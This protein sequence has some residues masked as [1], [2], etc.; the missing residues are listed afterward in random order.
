MKT[1]GLF[2]FAA[3]IAL[4][5]AFACGG[6][7]AETATVPP[8]APTATTAPSKAPTATLAPVAPTATSVP[9]TPTATV[10]P[11]TS[12]PV[13]TASDAV[14][15]L[16]NPKNTRGNVVF[17]LPDFDFTGGLNSV[18]AAYMEGVT[19]NL[20]WPTKEGLAT[21][22]IAKSWVVAN[23]LKSITITIRNGVSFHQ[24]FGE[25]TAEDV[26]WSFNDA[27]PG[28]TPDSITD[29][30]GQWTFFLGKNK[31]LAVD[32]YTVKFDLQMFDPRWDTSFFSQDGLSAS[33]TSKKAFD[34]KGRDWMLEHLV[35]TGP[36]EATELKTKDHALLTRV[37]NHWRAKP[38]VKTF[39]IQA[40]PDAGV[41]QATIETGEADVAM[42]DLN[43]ASD[44]LSRGFKQ[45]GNSKARQFMIVFNGNYWEDKNP[46]NGETIVFKE[47]YQQDVP[48]IGNPF[49]P[50][51]ANNP[52]GID[53]MEQARLV[54]QA[55]ARALDRNLLNEILLGGLGWPI[56][57]PYPGTRVPSWDHTKWVFPFD[58]K[59]AERLLEKAGYPKGA[60]G[61]RLQVPIVAS[62]DY[63]PE[64]SELSDAMAGMWQKV[65][66]KTAVVKAQYSAY[67]RPKLVGR[68]AEEPFLTACGGADSGRPPDWPLYEQFSALTRPGFNCGAELPF[69]TQ[70]LREIATEVDRTKRIAIAKEVSDYMFDQAIAPGIVAAPE[71]FLFNQ[72][73]ISSWEMGPALRH[74]WNT[75]ENIVLAK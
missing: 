74:S 49:K 37:E 33:I 69:L 20:F 50:A 71:I 36:F 40:V 17:A 44:L 61:E 38:E 3:A 70:K 73:S 25:L 54:R 32:K 10:A 45:V 60:N 35:G 24:N 13:P 30:G 62:I 64:F 47:V 53:D 68:R 29:G 51:D 39:K 16:P 52:S 34:T 56:A 2:L 4:V 28:V 42:V 59:E 66:V 63:A 58:V 22:L 19:E 18:G 75:P 48:W 41:R 57:L 6:S 43:V 27:N 55:L 5:A 1:R 46:N 23:D 26:A 67:I 14:S 72:K 31:A 8:A 65:G 9:I 11:A 21:P 15:K 12:T 7:E